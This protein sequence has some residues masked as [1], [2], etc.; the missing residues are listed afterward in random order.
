MI[1]FNLIFFLFTFILILFSVLGYGLFASSFLR[2]NNNNLSFGIFGLLGVFFSTLASYFTHIFIAHNIYHNLSF[3][4]IGLSLFFFFFIKNYLLY[5]IEIKKIILLII[6]FICCLFLSKNNE[7]FP[8]YHLPYTLNLVDSKLQF[9]IS[10][11]NIAFRTPSSLFYLQSL[12][13]LPYIK[14]YLFHSSNFII[15]IFCNLFF[16]DKFFFKKKEQSENY[17][18]K[19]LSCL[20]FTFI[21]I[22]FTGLAKFGTDRGGHIVAFVIF[23]L[24]LE[25]LNNKYLLVEKSKVIIILIIYLVSIK[26][27][28][29]PYLLLSLIIFFLL[30]KNNKLSKILLDYYFAFTV[31]LFLFLLLF[32]SFSNSGCL[33]YPLTLTCFENFYWSVSIES[34]NSLNNWYQLWSKAGAT[35]NYRVAN[36]D[37]YIKYL[38]W[39]PNWIHNY[40]LVKVLDTLVIIILIVVIFVT[41]LK[42]QK[43]LLKTNNKYISLYLFIIFFF[44]LWF[45]NHPDLRYGGYIL[46]ASIFF[47]PLSVYLSKFYYEKKITNKFFIIITLFSILIFNGKNFMRINSEFNRNDNFKYLNF[48]FYHIENITFK[49]K[50]LKDNVKIFIIESGHCWATPSPCLTT[51]V[52][53]K[54]IYGYVFFSK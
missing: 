38:N 49:E 33:I 42:K 45:F 9:G 2:L 51:I 27:Y 17:F 39:V 46:I 20:Y 50:V 29:S 18:I 23:I 53:A 37:E 52:N 44:L 30:I 5:K 14:Y 15:L 4:L 13:Y 16:L 1:L 19:L 11:F 35:P 21:C 47:I 24:I 31:I 7:D 25:C 22:T 6:L 8:Y 28:F 40:F 36:P 54:K 43:Y 10:H 34:V 26:S 3:H 12:F 41:Y 48:P 32:I